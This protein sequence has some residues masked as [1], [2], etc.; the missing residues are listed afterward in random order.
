MEL[1][2]ETPK[3]LTKH[4]KAILQDVKT[5]GKRKDCTI[6]FEFIGPDEL[7]KKLVDQVQITYNRAALKLDQNL[8][9]PA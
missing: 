6:I 4:K 8:Y 3:F 1:I 7:Y 5:G 2:F 9:F